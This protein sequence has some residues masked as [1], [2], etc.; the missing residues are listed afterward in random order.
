MNSQSYT[1]AKLSPR[2][3][4]QSGLY[5]LDSHSSRDPN[6][7]NTETLNSVPLLHPH[8]RS[9]MAQQILKRSSLLLSLANIEKNLKQPKCH[10]SIVAKPLTECDLFLLLSE[11]TRYRWIMA[12]RSEWKLMPFGIVWQKFLLH[13][14]L[15]L[16]PP[17]WKEKSQTQD[18]KY[19]S[20]AIYM[21]QI[22]V[23]VNWIDNRESSWT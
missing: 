8:P 7:G 10:A 4:S 11:T 13:W 20:S 15:N 9:F 23:H 5:E 17:S 2:G 19:C 3:R 12:S 14:S 1:K 21:R 22:R 6:P 16:R 18:S